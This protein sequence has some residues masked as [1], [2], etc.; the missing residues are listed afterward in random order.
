MI[1]DNCIVTVVKKDSDAFAQGIEVGDQV[2]S[3]RNFTPT[4][5]D[6]WKMS[7]VIYQLDPSNVMSL[8]IRKPDGTERS[9]VIK[10]KTLTDKE[11]REGIKERK[12][13]LK[14]RKE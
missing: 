10:A 5:A 7:Y 11:F 9:L 12:E 8:K 3:I 13:K 4:R 14:A 1:V 6:L 2:V